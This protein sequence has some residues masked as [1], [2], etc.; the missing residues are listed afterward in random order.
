VIFDRRAALDA[1]GE[2]LLDANR[3]IGQPTKLANIFGRK[4]TKRYRGKLETLIE[5]LDLP[6]PVIRSYYRDGSI[7]QATSN[8]VRDFGVP[9]ATDAVAHLR[10]AMAAVTDR[11][12]SVQQDILETFVDRGQLRQL[13]EPTHLPSGKRVPGLKLFQRRDPDR[14]H[15]RHISSAGNGHGLLGIRRREARYALPAWPTVL[16]EA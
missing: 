5:D 1:L 4:V 10:A 14:S 7:K 13:A 9:K 16:R 6:N 11:Y 3:T 8:N 2:R 12:Q 15:Q